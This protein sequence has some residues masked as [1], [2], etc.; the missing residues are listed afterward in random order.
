MYARYSIQ[1]RI[2]RQDFFRDSLKILRSHPG[3]KS[4]LGEPIKEM[5]FDLGD[6][7]RNLC[8]EIKGTARLQVAVKGPKERGNDFF[9]QINFADIA[10]KYYFFII[11]GTMLFWAE[12][13]EDNW[14][15][16]RVELALKNEPDKRLLIKGD[17][18]MPI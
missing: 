7:E 10:Y 2:R 9:F 5:G 3:A 13:T 1:E 6:E 15:V 8:D 4:L 14:N 18:A 16:F 11:S 12:K 17:K